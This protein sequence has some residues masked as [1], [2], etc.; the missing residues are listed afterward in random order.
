MNLSQAQ[1]AVMEPGDALFLDVLTVHASAQNRSDYD[2][3]AAIVN[4]YSRPKVATQT[5]SYG[6]TEPLRAPHQQLS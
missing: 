3:L 2:R 5:S 1:P 4:Y 6:S